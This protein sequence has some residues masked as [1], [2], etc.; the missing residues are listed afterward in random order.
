MIVE[1]DG[2]LK[3]NPWLF[4]RAVLG[5]SNTFSVG[6]VPVR[7]M[8]PDVLQGGFHDVVRLGFVLARWT[9]AAPAMLVRV[10]FT[11]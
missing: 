11:E 2:T 10:W 6:R 3:L 5:I 7:S 8:V 9:L 1:V 4:T